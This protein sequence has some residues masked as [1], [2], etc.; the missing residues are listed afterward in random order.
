MLQTI[1]YRLQANSDINLYLRRYVYG[2]P[3]TL[4]KQFTD[5]I[6]QNKQKKYIYNNDPIW[7]NKGGTPL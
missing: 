3:R 5:S 7:F 1:I 2:C 4:V 6:S